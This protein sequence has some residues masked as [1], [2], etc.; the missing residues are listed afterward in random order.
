MLCGVKNSITAGC[1]CDCH[2]ADAVVH[3]GAGTGVEAVGHGEEVLLA[4]IWL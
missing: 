1:R 3:A 4:G 2:V